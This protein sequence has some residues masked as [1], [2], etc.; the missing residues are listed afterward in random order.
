M[1]D[2]AARKGKDDKEAMTEISVIKNMQKAGENLSFFKKR[3]YT[4][5]NRTRASE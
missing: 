2:A 3:L 1:H 5:I 4:V